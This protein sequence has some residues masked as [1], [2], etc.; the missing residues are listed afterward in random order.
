VN[1]KIL[2]VF[3][4]FS[5]VAGNLYAQSDEFDFAFNLGNFG[6]GM[7]LSPDKKEGHFTYN[8]FN[9]YIEHKYTNIGLEIS[10]FNS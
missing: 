8:L 6:W 9:L 3:F 4:V 2:I 7:N 5:V 1:R 10:P